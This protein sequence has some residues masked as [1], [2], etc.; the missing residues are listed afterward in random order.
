M[1]TET[2]K[3]QRLSR[4]AAAR[5]RLGAALV[6]LAVAEEARHHAGTTTEG[7]AMATTTISAA[8]IDS[9]EWV[10]GANGNLVAF[11]ARANGTNQV[12]ALDGA[13]A[14]KLAEGI[15]AHLPPEPGESLEIETSAGPGE[16]EVTDMSVALPDSPSEPGASQRYQIRLGIGDQA[17]T[18]SMRHLELVRWMTRMQRDIQEHRRQHAN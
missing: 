9:V 13:Q 18:L 11:E 3:A 7:R 2:E 1:E 4:L 6:R 15:M 14:L 5:E 12:F 16:H 8:L 17:V 10:R